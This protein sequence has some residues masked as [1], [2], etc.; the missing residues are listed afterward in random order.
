MR[1]ARLRLALTAGLCLVLSLVACSTDSSSGED[2]DPF[3]EVPTFPIAVD[4]PETPPPT[5]DPSPPI[6]EFVSEL[7][8]PGPTLDAAGRVFFRNGRN[9]WTITNDVTEPALEAGTRF[10]PYE[11]SPHGQRAAVVIIS[12][13]ESQQAEMV[14]II[15]N[16]E[17]GPPLTSPR[18]ISGPDAQSSIRALS[19]SRDATR[20]AIVYDEPAIAILEIARPDGSPPAIVSEFRLP[21]DYRRIERVE[22]PTTG[23][24]LAILADTPNGRA[25]LL[26][27]SLDGELFE[28][29]EAGM[30]G[31]RSIADMTWLPGRGR[32]AFIE[33]RTAGSL[34]SGGSMFSIAPDGSGRE[35]LVSSGNFSPA[36]ELVKLAASPRG[37]F[38]AFSV[39]VP[40]SQGEDTFHSAWLVNLD[41]G[42]LTRIPVT[43]GFRLTNFWW[44]TEGILWR[45]VH[46]DAPVVDSIATYAGL[47]PFILGRF[48]PDTGESRSLF[49]SAAN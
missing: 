28:V 31:T 9:L 37:S 33:E 22:W 13:V 43:S 26:V 47:E 49:H 2:D 32:A 38:V 40:G 36:A 12:D 39:N 10:G 48:N 5:V 16:G 8:A 25:A 23:N 34:P 35:L 4:E 27:A 46:R 11:T 44:T 18:F 45:A 20:I 30:D 41:S 17:L 3:S 19:W 6:P 21:D 42:E 29:T 15:A 14:H 24:G 1:P 7:L